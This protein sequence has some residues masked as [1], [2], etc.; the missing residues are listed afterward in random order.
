M[1]CPLTESD[2]ATVRDVIARGWLGS[3]GAERRLGS[4]TLHDHQISAVARLRVA[5]AEFGGALLADAVGLGKTYVALAVAQQYEQRIVVAPAAL[6]QMW[7]EAMTQACVAMHFV[8]LES[9]S[10]NESTLHGHS[11]VVVDEA[12]H[13]RNSHTRRYA[14]LAALCRHAHVLLVSA[15][16][17]HNQPREL[18]ALLALFIGS[19]GASLSTAELARLI[20]RRTAAATSAAAAA[21]LT[22]R[23]RWLRIEHDCGVRDDAL[24]QALLN[25][26][27]PV[28]PSDGGHAGQLVAHALLRQAA[29]SEAALHGA[30][31]RRLARAD[32]LVMALQS[33]RYP[34]AGELRAWTFA[35]DSLQLAFPEMIAAASSSVADP[36]SAGGLQRALDEHTAA[37]RKILETLSSTSPRDEARAAVLAAVRHAHPNEKIVA[38]SQFGDTVRALYRALRNQGRVAALTASGGLVAGG[39]ITRRD[40]VAR[41]APRACGALPPGAADEITL[42]LTTDLLS[43]GVN[44]QD[45]S[46]V[47]H[48]DVPWTPARLDQRVGRVARLGSACQ[49]VSVYALTPPSSFERALGSFAFLRRKQAH[50]TRMIGARQIRN[51][52]A[53]EVATPAPQSAPERVEALRTLLSGWLQP[54]AAREARPE[55]IIAATNAD[56]WGFLALCTY[57]AVPVLV[58]ALNVHGQTT[59]AREAT[60]LAILSE[61]HS[62]GLAFAATTDLDTVLATTRAATCEQRLSRLPGH[63]N[64][65][66][67]HLPFVTLTTAGA[68]LRSIITLHRA[69][70][71][72][73]ATGGA[74]A[75]VGQ[76]A[77]GRKRRALFR[78]VAAAA[79]QAPPA[80]RPW[81]AHLAGLAATT[82]AQRNSAALERSF[83]ELLT[84]ETMGEGLLGRLARPDA[85][86]P[87]RQV[88]CARTSATFAVRAILLLVPRSD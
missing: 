81:V 41:F 76:S 44:L 77:C 17:I 67:T 12:H 49:V 51:V 9:L 11:F 56:R 18:S 29:S 1:D 84:E 30:V 79:R 28:P 21:P 10:R 7:R 58:A 13:A 37:L 3:T 80:S 63:P 43:E 39:R 14:A 55:T 50:M 24:A 53:S 68:A 16:P 5:I 48:L 59:G 88:N 6:R 15:T 70:L 23:T 20:I 66:E 57:D 33:G 47:L 83:E 40:A 85:A 8:S 69:T 46:V 27:P 25:L 65:I 26:P 42:L 87:P 19:A 35:E 4:V 74:L 86:M 31:R 2:V 36:V 52:D 45:A 61:E 22:R 82:L 32:S 64:S 73:A 54:L 60:R 62:E 72:T 78:R 38:F 34:A 71:A 75:T